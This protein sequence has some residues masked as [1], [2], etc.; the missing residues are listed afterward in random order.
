MFD[1]NADILDFMGFQ[2]L[3]MSKHVGCAIETLICTP[4][5]CTPYLLRIFEITEIWV[6]VIGTLK[7]TSHTRAYVQKS[8]RERWGMNDIVP[9]TKPKHV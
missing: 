6:W 1:S 2:K 9:K 3:E 8:M 5:N 4:Q 7:H